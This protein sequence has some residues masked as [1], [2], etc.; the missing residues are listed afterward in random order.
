MNY[1]GKS[2][3][4]SHPF[5]VYIIIHHIW[6]FQ[7]DSLKLVPTGGRRILIFASKIEWEE[8]SCKDFN[9]ASSTLGWLAPPPT[10]TLINSSQSASAQVTES[11]WSHGHGRSIARDYAGSFI[12]VNTSACLKVKYSVASNPFFLAM[13]KVKPTTRKSRKGKKRET[14]EVP[15]ERTEAKSLMLREIREEGYV[16]LD[17]IALQSCRLRSKEKKIK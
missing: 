12:F 8:I 13:G 9:S 3:N 10:W 7:S 2:E 11:W 16:S 14:A 15:I 6:K 4:S 1:K 17:S 5:W